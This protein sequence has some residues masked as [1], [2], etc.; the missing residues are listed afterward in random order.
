[1]APIGIFI[2]V[3]AIPPVL[4]IT[5]SRW[6][7]WN[8]STATSEQE[9]RYAPP[10]Q[11]LQVL[12]TS[13]AIWV[14]VIL[15]GMAFQA[16]GLVDW[17]ALLAWSALVWAPLLWAVSC[18]NARR[19]RWNAEGIEVTWLSGEPRLTRWDDIVQGGLPNMAVSIFWTTTKQRSAS[20]LVF[21]M[22]HE[23]YWEMKRRLGGRFVANPDDEAMLGKQSR[24]TS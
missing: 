17:I 14:G 2:C 24:Q 5:I 22:G 8:K 7:T 16:Q 3:M 1:M 18:I 4:S 6:W 13:A 12:L 11:P 9:W 19:V 10:R 15:F 20:S 21:R 23:L